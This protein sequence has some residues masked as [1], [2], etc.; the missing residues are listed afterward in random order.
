MKKRIKKY[1]S[2]LIVTVMVVSMFTISNI[3]TVAANATLTPTSATV[4]NDCP[5][6][7]QATFTSGYANT[8]VNQL[9]NWSRLRLTSGD[10][11]EYTSHTYDC[12]GW[13]A[14][15]YTVQIA[16]G[17]QNWYSTPYGWLTLDNWGDGW[18]DAGT[19]TVLSGGHTWNSGTVTTEPTCTAKG[20]R[21]YTCTSCNGTK[22]ED[23]AALGHIWDSG[24]IT[25]QPTC[26]Q[27]GV[28]TYTC[29]RDNSHTY[30][31]PVALLGH[32]YSSTSTDSSHLKSAATCT[33]SAVYYYSCSRCGANGTET[34]TYGNPLGHSWNGGEM[35][36]APTPDDMGTTRYTCTRC[37]QTRDE[38]DIPVLT[39][40]DVVIYYATQVIDQYNNGQLFTSKE[41]F[42][43]AWTDFMGAYDAAVA[44][45]SG[46]DEEI[47][48]AA[49]ELLMQM[50]NISVY[51]PID[52]T[53]L[54]TALAL[55]P[56]YPVQYYT[57]TS[58]S[59]WTTACANAQTFISKAATGEKALSDQL[60]MEDLKMVLT[61]AYNSLTLK[62]ADY[63]A[64]DAL[65]NLESVQNVD[66]YV[67]TVADPVR[68][69]LAEIEHD[70]PITEQ[71]TV[72][73]WTQSLT[74]AAA[75]LTSANLDYAD[76]TEVDAAI[77]RANALTPS[78]YTNF[79]A[80]TD[81]IAAVDRTI[82]R[83][84]QDTVD[85]MAQ[86]INNAIDDLIPERANYE[87]LTARVA[88]AEALDEDL[89]INYFIVQNVIDTI[90][91]NLDVF[92]QSQ[93]NTKLE[94]LNA[95]ISALEYADADYSAVNTALDRVD[96]LGDLSDY[97][98][99]SLEA[100]DSA[101]AA[102][103]EGLKANEQAL[104]DS[105][106]QTL[107]DTIDSM[108]LLLADYTSVE[109]AVAALEMLDE[110][111][112]T[113]YAIVTN[114]INAIDWTIDCRHQ[115]DV[116][117][118][119]QSLLAIQN[120]L[121]ADGA[122]YTAVNEKLAA[123]QEMI[124]NSEYPYDEDSL[125]E[126]NAFVANLDMDL[127]V[128]HQDIVDSYVD[129]IEAAA[130]NLKYVLADYTALNA[131]VASANAIDRTLYEDL[132]ELDGAIR[133]V[134][135][136]VRID[137]QHEVDAM[138]ARINNALNNLQL[139]PADYS[140]LDMYLG[141][142]EA[143]N[144]NY[145]T[146]EDIAYVD[147]VI[148]STVVRG[149]TKDQ[150]SDVN[151]MAQTVYAAV[152][153]LDDK[154]LGADLTALDA[155]VAAANAKVVQM[156]ATEYEIVP[157]L[158]ES[159]QEL[160]DT[161]VHYDGAYISAQGEIDQLTQDI[162]DATDALEF[163]FTITDDTTAIIDEGIVYGFEE[164][165]TAAE[166][167]SMIS[168]VGSATMEVVE[169]ANGLGTGSQIIYKDADGNVIDEFTLVI[170]GDAN[171]D[172]W[173][174]MFDV[175]IISEIANSGAEVDDYLNEAL[176]LNDDGFIDAYD[177]AIMISVANMDAS[178]SQDGNFTVA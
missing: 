17:G 39:G 132:S 11:N 84:E 109:N 30:T 90:N 12:Y 178:I 135:Y 44:A 13:A 145:Y 170:F 95:A 99:E 117:A 76:Y 57:D 122:D 115:S 114:A 167:D 102:V 97:T 149:L 116:E 148:E 52:V 40:I 164:G 111:N 15:T 78:N 128:F 74:A 36:I 100:L 2:L 55:T 80:V 68:A 158:L 163:V 131:A 161:T 24:E 7:S 81:A 67:D 159:L 48:N 105:M 41:G 165:I 51:R 64:L 22:T 103:V 129:Q 70:L 88:Y 86:A 21:T 1:L 59:A 79:S 124:E 144:K 123:V 169:T 157:E 162:I 146:A 66:D 151:A 168:F 147:G 118:L 130:L 42:S 106:A 91:W 153:Y 27:D 25:T 29:T 125:A 33:E 6:R 46:T 62:K 94:Q 101:I 92:H 121:I 112:Y 10:T 127:D 137:R 18:R 113:N 4:Y 171:G 89:Y 61:Y 134:D 98:E 72:D 141:E 23:I 176:D 174:D 175:S 136:D 3:S 53:S 83:K 35:L 96:T 31:E 26:T 172:G 143:M 160:I 138:T 32:D 85:E 50:S 71:A 140:E 110:S 120:D 63:T 65:C 49:V 82:L 77:A 154:M 38:V 20:T 56:E 19:L 54:Q 166:I 155:A 45:K 139:L 28:K 152:R 104:V 133:D 93:V 5:A 37:L 34:F 69:I 177:I 9:E 8:A 43:S 73:A 14:G 173:I 126:Y 119:A 142:Y 75:N 107:N 47:T 87:E 150:Q 156:Q 108:E 58:Y 60:E 16:A